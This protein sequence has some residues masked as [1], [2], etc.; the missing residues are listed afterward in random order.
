MES[1]RKRKTAPE[2]DK[3]EMESE[4]RRQKLEALN[5]HADFGF[6]V[7]TEKETAEVNSTITSQFTVNH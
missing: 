5:D 2:M 6:I 3:S 7:G 4:M 1:S